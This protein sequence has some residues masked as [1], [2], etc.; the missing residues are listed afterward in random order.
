MISM[1]MFLAELKKL[2]LLFRA[3]PKSIGAG[4]MPPTIILLAFFVTVG[5]FDS[6]EIS[7]IN[8]DVGIY[9]EM[10][11]KSILSEKSPLGDKVYFEEV[12]LNLEET[13]EKFASE[14]LYAYVVIPEDFS[15]ILQNGGT[16][17]VEYYF[18]NY[19]TDVAKNLRLYLT[20]GV[21]DFYKA[22]DDGI[23]VEVI[24]EM[25]VEKQLPWFDIIAS[26]VF[27]L[28]FL[29]GV[30]INTL[31]LLS[32]ERRNGTM[33]NYQLAPNNVFPSIAA[34]AVVALLS[35]TITAT[36]NGIIIYLLTGKNYLPYVLEILPALIIVGLTYIFFA[37]VIG[38]YVDSFAGSIVASLIG[39]VLIWFLSGATFSIKNNTGI[40]RTVCEWLPNTYALSHIRGVVFGM[41]PSIGSISYAAGWRIMS[42][43]LFVALSLAIYAYYR[44]L[45]RCYK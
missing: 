11:E 29:L 41:D 45:V 15:Q 19:N 12:E 9:G 20:E 40:L 18:N 28:A 8:N 5:N 31:Y 6:I 22:T 16:P 24:E 23:Q 44:K 26:G 14:E 37:I 33:L 25:N 4:I 34:R 27:M 32:M 42:I 38:L 21:L 36:V 3:D 35:G 2:L 43:Y 17:D 30:V 39:T 10:L 13:R 7:I 1:R